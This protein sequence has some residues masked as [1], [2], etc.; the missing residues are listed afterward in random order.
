MQVSLRQRRRGSFARHPWGTKLAFA[1]ALL[2]FHLSSVTSAHAQTPPSDN[3]DA[4]AAQT[5]PPSNHGA[6]DPPKD[7]SKNPNRSVGDHSFIFPALVDSAF[8][9]TYVGIRLRVASFDMPNLPTDFG[10]LHISALNVAEGLDVGFRI[11]DILGVWATFGARTFIATNAK[12]LVYEGATFDYGG[13]AGAILRLLRNEK[14][15]T[16]LALRGSFGLSKGQVSSL[17]G[18]FPTTDTSVEIANVVDSQLLRTPIHETNF[19][20]SLAVAQSLSAM[21][22]LQASVGLGWSS[23]TFEPYDVTTG[24]RAEKHRRGLTYQGGVAVSCDFMAV[25]FPLALMAEYRLSRQTSNP[26][27]VRTTELSS[28]SGLYGGVYYSGRPNLQ[29]GVGGGVDLGLA[30]GTTR[31]GNSDAPRLISGQLILRYVW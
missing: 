30:P 29:L 5:P 8:V 9:A 24:A 2:A 21:F 16:Q 23:L 19:G 18:L 14:S 13:N 6:T 11:V 1:S 20:G 17:A 3:D 31:F 25:R 10:N 28:I 4:T 26:G 22:G 15:G 12:S 7:E 27:A